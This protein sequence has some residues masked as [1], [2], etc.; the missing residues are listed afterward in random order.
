MLLENKELNIQEQQ[1]VAQNYKIGEPRR[2]SVGNVRVM[3]IQIARASKRSSW[4]GGTITATEPYPNQDP[5]KM[6]TGLCCQS[7]EVGDRR[8]R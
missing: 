7:E 2:S 6:H 8:R 1:G 3:R 5:A 4:D